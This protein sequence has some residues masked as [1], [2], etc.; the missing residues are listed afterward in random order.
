MTA[1]I[2]RRRPVTTDDG[3]GGQTV[4]W[5]SGAA[6]PAEVLPVD[7]RERTIAGAVQTAATHSVTVR[8]DGGWAVEQRIEQVSPPGPLLEIVGVRDPDGRRRWLEL[9]CR[10]VVG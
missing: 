6:V 9:E 3:Q 2:R 8:Q 4:S 5:R 7:S 10:E 1:W